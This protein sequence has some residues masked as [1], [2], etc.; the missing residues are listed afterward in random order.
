MA[1]THGQ[2]HL[3]M[4]YYWVSDINHT[5]HPLEKN[6][7]EIPHCPLWIFGLDS[8]RGCS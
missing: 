7:L 6:L 5:S 1:D 4:S 2:E 8:G 3:K